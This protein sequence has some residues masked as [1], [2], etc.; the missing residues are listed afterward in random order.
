MGSA[1]EVDLPV[2]LE[3]SRP[4]SPNR[5]RENEVI[6]KVEEHFN[7]HEIADV[8]LGAFSQYLFVDTGSIRS[9][10]SIG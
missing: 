5:Y 9:I 8:L 6:P 10:R 1:H 3:P 4:G 7:V 2:A